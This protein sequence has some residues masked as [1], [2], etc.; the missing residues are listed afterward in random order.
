M[1]KPLLIE[2]IRNVIDDYHYALDIYQIKYIDV[3]I[4]QDKA[5]KT[6]EQI[7]NKTWNPGEEKEKRDKVKSNVTPICPGWP[8]TKFTGSQRGVPNK[9]RENKN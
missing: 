1:R 4:A 6:I 8:P 2:A 7:L 9:Q 3:S 5:I